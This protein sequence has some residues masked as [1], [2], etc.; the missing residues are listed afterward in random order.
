M[1]YRF[2]STSSYVCKDAT[3]GFCERP[4]CRQLCERPSCEELAEQQVEGKP[5]CGQL[6]CR[7]WAMKQT[8]QEVRDRQSL[9]RQ[10]YLHLFLYGAFIG[11][12]LSEMF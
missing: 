2:N 5:V 9:F 7:Y 1:P 12:V 10:N 6:I 3:C 11:Y 4:G 8:L